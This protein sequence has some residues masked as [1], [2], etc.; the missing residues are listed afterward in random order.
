[1][2]PGFRECTSTTFDAYIGFVEH[3]YN[4]DGDYFYQSILRVVQCS[5]SSLISKIK[6][7]PASV[8]NNQ[9]SFGSIHS[10]K[11]ALPPHVFS[12][13]EYQN[14][15]SDKNGL[16]VTLVK[17]NIL[18]NVSNKEYSL[19]FSKSSFRKTLK[20]L[21]M[22]GEYNKTKKRSTPMYCYRRTITCTRYPKF[23]CEWLT[24]DSS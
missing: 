10:G 8:K 1:M 22:C 5:Y 13:S 3:L 14:F 19:Y 7:S 4:K 17:I 20:K 21:T 15:L 11:V 18:K 12:C 16:T 24:S 2:L 6:I 9:A 23:F